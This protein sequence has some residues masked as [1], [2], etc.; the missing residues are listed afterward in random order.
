L[1]ETFV[2]FGLELKA[3]TPFT[4][5]FTISIANGAFGYLPTVEQ[6]QLGGY[7]IWLGVNRVE[8][9][10]APKM[11][12][13][14]LTMRRELKSENAVE[15]SSWKTSAKWRGSSRRMPL[16]S[17]RRARWRNWSPTTKRATSASWNARPSTRC[18][19]DVLLACQP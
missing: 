4:R 10:A 7:E 17:R 18:P 1:I 5:S 13:R 12:T 15:W 6:H 3:K 11:L 2:E 8:H 16:A 9:D 14:L 19:R